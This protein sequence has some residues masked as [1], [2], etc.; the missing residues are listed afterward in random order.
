MAHP[1]IPNP[2]ADI[3]KDSAP[4]YHVAL[5]DQEFNFQEL[6][7]QDQYIENEDHH[8]P[9]P[10][11][12]DTEFCGPGDHMYQNFCKPIFV[13]HMMPATQINRLLDLWVSTLTKHNDRPPFADHHDLY[14]TIDNIPVGDV[15]WQSFLAHYTG[16]RPDVAPPWMDQTFD[17][18]YQDPHQ[19]VRNMLGNPDYIQEF[20]YC[21]Y[22]EFSTDGDVWQWK[23]FMSGD[24]A[25]DQAIGPSIYLRKITS[26]NFQDLIVTDPETH[27][28]AF[29]PVILGSDKTTV[30]VATGNNEYYP[31]YASIGNV[32][33]NV[34]H[35][36]R[37]ALA[38]T[39][40]LAI[41]KTHRHTILPF[42]SSLVHHTTPHQLLSLQLTGAP[43]HTSS[44]SF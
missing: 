2:L 41:P 40:F 1:I 27:G 32:R 13:M 4:E 14:K 12:I 38:I 6:E 24:W 35:A 15:K 43:H 18:W 31:L 21:P 10:P 30:S 17:V 9:L 29:V 36:H 23:D 11:N 37:E 3:A 8:L 16:V 42:S 19:V 5:A 33:N 25:W 7:H 44:A 34:W 26:D 22:H 20:D 39:G 28:S